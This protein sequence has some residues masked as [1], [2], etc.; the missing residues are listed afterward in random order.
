MVFNSGS[1][2]TDES[3]LRFGDIGTAVALNATLV[4]RVKN[5][6]GPTALNFVSEKALTYRDNGVHEF[7]ERQGIVD[8]NIFTKN[9]FS[10]FFFSANN[11]CACKTNI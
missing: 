11:R 3:V 5:H 8:R 1:T 10:N 6:Y 4:V 2:A 7:L 9:I